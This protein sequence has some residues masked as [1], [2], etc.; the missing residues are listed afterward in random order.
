MQCI[1][2]LLIVFLCI[3]L[4]R[5]H[6]WWDNSRGYIKSPELERWSY[7][8]RIEKEARICKKSFWKKSFQNDGQKNS[9]FSGCAKICWRKYFLAE[10]TSP[11][12]DTRFLLYMMQGITLF[13][14][15]KM[16]L[17]IIK[18]ASELSV[19]YAKIYGFSCFYLI[20]RQVRRGTGMASMLCNNS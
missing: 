18:M 19:F 1:L 3:C 9:R 17:F 7:L 6:R 10:C 4:D 2:F 14:P 20:C 8:F 11:S 16:M 15:N 12:H 5:Y 13:W